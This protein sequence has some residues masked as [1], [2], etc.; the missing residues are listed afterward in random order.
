ML[1]T[2]RSAKKVAAKGYMSA[3]E[4]AKAHKNGD[5]T[6]DQTRAMM[7][8]HFPLSEKNPIS[9]KALNLGAKGVAGSATAVI[10]GLNKVPGGRKVVTSGA[11]LVEYGSGI[12][13]AVLSDTAKKLDDEMKYKFFTDND[14]IDET[15]L[16]EEQFKVLNHTDIGITGLFDLLYNVCIAYV[17]ASKKSD[18]TPDFTKIEGLEDQIK[19]LYDLMNDTN[20]QGTYGS[21]FMTPKNRGNLRAEETY[22]T[23]AQGGSSCSRKHKKSRKNKNSKNSKKGKN[24]KRVTRKHRGGAKKTRKSNKNTKR[25]QHKHRRTKRKC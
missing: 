21:I 8:R 6:Q 15:K 11:G 19:Q 17:M 2:I 24:G 10:K 9:S 1:T 4:L 23:T 5:V 20:F 12:G 18:M 14:I 22:P 7:D 3:N 16:T 25:K 13:T